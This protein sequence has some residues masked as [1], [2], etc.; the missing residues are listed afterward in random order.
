MWIGLAPYVPQHRPRAVARWWVAC[1]NP[2]VVDES[3][4]PPGA[5]DGPFGLAAPTSLPVEFLAYLDR[6]GVDPAEITANRLFAHARTFA[7]QRERG[8]RHP[9]R[10][11]DESLS[12]LDRRRLP[13]YHASLPLLAH[14]PIEVDVPAYLEAHEMPHTGLRGDAQANRE[15]S[16]LRADAV[17][18]YLEAAHGVDPNRLRVSG[19]GSSEPLPRRPGEK[20]RAY[21]YRLPRVELSLVTEVY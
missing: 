9:L 7:S 1:G 19:R 15:L 8:K 6:C 2:V 5:I 16:E 17:S 13:L 18:R 3:A 21:N 4:E 10:R 14:D 20:D 12:A 11:D